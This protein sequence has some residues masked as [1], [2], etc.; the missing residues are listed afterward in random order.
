MRNSTLPLLTPRAPPALMELTSL[1]IDAVRTAVQDREITAVALA[2]AFY[3]KIA[4]DDPQIGAY[5]TLSKD[6]ALAKASQ[7]DALAAKGEK[8]PDI[9]G[10]NA[11]IAEIMRAAKG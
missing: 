9:N 5:L 2:E 4:K 1:T 11:R 10:T 6:R 7:I 8:L 3:S